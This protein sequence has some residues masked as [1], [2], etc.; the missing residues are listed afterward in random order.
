MSANL[1]DSD[2]R[3][4]VRLVADAAVFGTD[5]AEKKRFVMEGLCEMIHAD[6]WVWALMCQPGNGQPQVYVNLLH[7]GFDEQGFASFLEAVEHPDMS[8]VAQSFF[9]ELERKKTHITRTRE[10]IIE[11]EVYLET[12]AAGLWAEA[13]IGPVIFSTRPL[14]GEAGSSIGIYRSTDAA[15]FTEREAKMAHIILTEVSWLHLMGWPEDRGATVPKLL[16]R[17]RIVLNLLLDGA[18]RKSI[19]DQLGLSIHT[20]NGYCKSIYRHFSVNSQAALMAR[21]LKGD[22]GE[23]P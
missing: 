6:S 11:D 17:E 7:G 18:D 8:W 5:H 2:V 3:A 10:Q 9:E 12:K 22:G 14:G 23:A 4:L 16:P 21:F 20:V 1:E 13:G 19:A 15:P